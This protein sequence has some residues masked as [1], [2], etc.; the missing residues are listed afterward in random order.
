MVL[1]RARKVASSSSFW[2]KLDLV[3]SSL[4]SDTFL[5]SIH[6]CSSS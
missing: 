3:E 4:L 1:L 2:V 5:N 6:S